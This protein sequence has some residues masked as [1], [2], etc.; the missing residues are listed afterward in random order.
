[1]KAIWSFWTKPIRSRSTWSWSSQKHHLLSWVL[2]VERARLHYPNTTLYTDDAGARM[3]VEGIGLQFDHVFT[4][5]NGLEHADP[6]W[7]ALGKICTYA[8]QKEPFVHIDSDV[9][10][11]K[12]FP[13]KVAQADVFLQN[14][15][16]F[17]RGGV[18]YQPEVL[19]KA[20]HKAPGGWM[21]DEWEWYRS[22]GTMQQGE[23]CGV[24]G[25]N[26][27]D[28]ISYYARQALKLLDHSANQAAL[29]AMDDKWEHMVLVEQYLLSACI[30]YHQQSEKS[31]Y[32][33]LTVKY[34][35][36][37]MDEAFNPGEAA[38]LGYTHLLGGSKRNQ[39]ITEKLERRVK[40]DYPELYERCLKYLEQLSD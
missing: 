12:P 15:E 25:G 5:L 8:S 39:D 20:I 19:E 37:S 2:S 27:V 23:C 40:M 3:L 31:P 24:F 28:F 10:L 11:W 34:L 32:R 18:F 9:Y 13:E 26:R 6:G 35:F 14:P 38:R 7:W 17:N 21:P 16:P 36:S 29:W 33:D 1:M 4:D 30:H 22:E